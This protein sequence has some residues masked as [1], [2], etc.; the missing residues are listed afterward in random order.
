MTLLMHIRK[1]DD[2]PHGRKTV[3]GF[4]SMDKEP[5]GDWTIELKNPHLADLFAEGHDLR[6]EATE[7]REAA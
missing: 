4:F 2:A 1:V 5:A 7:L 6:I 3:H